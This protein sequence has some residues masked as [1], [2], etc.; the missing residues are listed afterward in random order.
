[1]EGEEV[2]SGDEPDSL[3]RPEHRRRRRREERREEVLTS[4]D[5]VISHQDLDRRRHPEGE[6]RRRKKKASRNVS[7]QTVQLMNGQSI[8]ENEVDASLFQSL[9][10]MGRTKIRRNGD[11]RRSTKVRESS[12]GSELMRSRTRENTDKLMQDEE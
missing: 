5:Q 8:P 1:M 4:P 7:E 10:D 3:A 2:K 11:R 12:M 6:E 9:M